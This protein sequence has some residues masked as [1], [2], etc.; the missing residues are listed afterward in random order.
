MSTI[1]KNNMWAACQLTM[2]IQYDGKL[3]QNYKNK[4]TYKNAG[5]TEEVYS[6]QDSQYGIHAGLIGLAGSNIILA[7]RGTDGTLDWLNDFNYIQIPFSYSGKVI[8]T[9][10]VHTGFYDAIMSISDEIINKLKEL[11]KLTSNS[12]IYVTGHSKGG[13]MATLLAKILQ[14]EDFTNIFVVTFGS[15][16]VGDENFKKEYTISHERYESFLDL[17]PHMPFTDQEQ[18]LM[19]K[20]NSLYETAGNIPLLKII[21]QLLTKSKPYFSVGKLNCIY[22]KHG[23]YGNYP[24]ET[25]NDLGETLNS[26]CAVEQIVRSVDLTLINDIH[27]NDYPG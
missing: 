12:K 20:L 10:K 19:P 25:K 4:E 5:F 22:K 9:G 6:Y 24:Y 17:I 18:I 14:Y 26:L 23:K 13:A 8:G 21:Y 27:N 2:D 7:F 3:P 16:R 15:P 11:K 1:D